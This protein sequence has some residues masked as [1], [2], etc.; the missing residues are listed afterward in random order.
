MKLATMVGAQSKQKVFLHLSLGLSFLQV[1]YRDGRVA[2][3]TGEK[4][5]VPCSPSSLSHQWLQIIVEKN[6]QDD[7]DGG[8]RG[9]VKTKG[10]RGPGFVMS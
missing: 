6:P 9:R 5:S 7:Y 10:K 4:V 3:R 1:R 2:T 8:S